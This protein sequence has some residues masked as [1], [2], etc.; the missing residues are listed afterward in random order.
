L[1]RSTAYGASGRRRV[2][3]RLKLASPCASR[4]R[5]NSRC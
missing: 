5:R 1:I 3:L 4:V 2:W